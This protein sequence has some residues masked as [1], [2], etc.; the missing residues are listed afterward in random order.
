MSERKTATNYF[1][2][3]RNPEGIR[4]YREELDRIIV[5][6]AAFGTAY[7]TI[8]LDQHGDLVIRLAERPGVQGL[9]V[10]GDHDQEGG[11]VPGAT[12]RYSP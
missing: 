8:E 10:R 7:Y 5:E 6:A 12:L 1:A 11:D 9:Q 2:Q 4:K 3:A